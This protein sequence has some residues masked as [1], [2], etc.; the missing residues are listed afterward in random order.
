MIRTSSSARITGRTVR[1]WTCR[2][3]QPRVG[4]EC[5]CVRVVYLYIHVWRAVLASTR[6][7][8]CTLSSPSESTHRETDDSDE[9]R[10]TCSLL[11]LGAE[12]E[13]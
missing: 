13:C 3:S 10:V 12:S 6:G 1:L 5:P 2:L 9:T 11:L 8:L 7:V 4:P